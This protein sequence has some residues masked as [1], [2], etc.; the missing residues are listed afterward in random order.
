M[1]EKKHFICTHTWSSTEAREEA[2]KSMEKMT[3]REFFNSLR[4]DKAETLQ[5]WMGSDD[6]FFCHWYAESEDAIYESLDKSG[7]SSLMITL[8]SE[9]PRFVT[10]YDIKDSIM[11]SPDNP[12]L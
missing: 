3:D 2:L 7:F 12:N 6:F 11:N 10:Q 8:P 4:T 9:M 5:H 1:A